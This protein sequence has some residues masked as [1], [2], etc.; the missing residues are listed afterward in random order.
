VEELAVDADVVAGGVGFGA[1]FSDGLAVD[2][3]ASGGDQ[4]FGFAAR[5]DAG[6]GDDFLQS[7]RGASVG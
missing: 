6:S 3:D 2:L 5:G 4:L 7:L 1:E